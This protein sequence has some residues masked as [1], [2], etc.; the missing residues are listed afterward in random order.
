MVNGA[1]KLGKW[2][3]LACAALSALSGLCAGCGQENPVDEPDQTLQPYH[4]LVAGSRWQ[5]AHSDWDEVVT[6]ETVEVDGQPSFLMSDSPNPSDDLRSDAVI[7]SVDGRVVR[8]KKDE[9]LVG[10]GGTTTLTSSTTY[11]VGFTRFNEGWANQQVGY[12]EAPEYVRVETRPNESTPRPPEGRK[13]TFTVMNLHAEVQ[14]PMGPFDCI[15]IK[16]T[17]DWEAEEE[18]VDASD[19]DAKTFWF[20]R[21]VGK[22]QERND[23]TGST[24]VLTSYAIPAL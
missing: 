6:L 12:Q 2:T 17:K 5:Y 7:A 14:T 15:E 4:P 19:A 23:E 21:G 9:F 24:E 18:G 11:G 20:A 1:R 10:S 13:H 8:V 3:T 22:V 16:R